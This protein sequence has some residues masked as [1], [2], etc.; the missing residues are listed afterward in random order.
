MVSAVRL[1][2]FTECIF[3]APD[4][5]DDDAAQLADHLVWADLRGASWLGARK[6]IQYVQRIRAGGTS[7]NAVPVVLQDRGVFTLIDA[8][9]TTRTG[10]GRPR[11]AD[12]RR[13]AS[14]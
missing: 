11:H 9:D 5:R 10:G 7:P 6:I 8:K 14:L 3:C 12:G 2:R 4:M 13:V 1:R